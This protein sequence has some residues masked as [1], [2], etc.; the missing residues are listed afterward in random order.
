MKS[1]KL[2]EIK[3]GNNLEGAGE[4][5]VKGGIYDAESG[6]LELS[7]GQTASFECYFNIFP[8][9]QYKKYCDI[10]VFFLQIDAQGRYRT[11]I[12][13]RQ[14]NGTKLIKS[15][16]CEGAMRTDISADDGALYTFFTV[17][18]ESDC[19]FFRAAWLCAEDARR[20]TKLGMV[21]CTYR[22]EEF[23][24][25]NI[26]RI[27]AAVENKPDWKEKLHIFIVD[28]A[29][30]LSLEDSDLYTVIP[31]RN[32]GGSGGFTRGI[33][34]VCAD[35]SFS[36]FLLTD[37]DIYFDFETLE[38]T[39]A[40]IS[41][42]TCKH[43]NATV[44]G[45][46][47]YLDRPYMQHEFGGKFDG[48]IFT[49]INSKLDMRLA[50]NLL[51]NENAPAAGY[52]AWWY[53]CMP[54]S[55]V[56]NFGLPM[57]FFIKGDDVEYGMRA[58]EELIRMNGIA[59]WHQDF[60]KKFSASLEYYKRNEAVVAALATECSPFKV[61]V[62]FAYFALKNLTM[63][64]YDCTELVLKGYEDF[65]RGP[66]FFAS[67]DPFE[68]NDEIRAVQPEWISREQIEDMCGPIDIKDSQNVKLSRGERMM[69]A[70]MAVENYAPAFMF[71]KKPAVT[72][73]F[74]PKA[75][76]AFLKKTVI[77]FDE[78]SDRGF[79][80]RLD[81]ARRKKLRRRTV[82]MFFRLLTGFKK[83]RKLYREERG[84]MCSEE[85]W[86]RIFFPPQ[87]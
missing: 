63:K 25:S 70:L 28:N 48:L 57:P 84:M 79:V 65:F 17:T 67:A 18:A 73:A 35:P 8:H 4:M 34:Q 6:R 68:I 38:R 43:E 83:M 32:T 13:A 54:V 1:V 2:F 81:T 50:D 40:L 10:G 76:E 46:M 33:M 64:N 26:M 23:V 39:Y 52:N 31:N 71:S 59:V 37:D 11:D 66:Q 16:D 30:T 62:R 49:A 61:A 45:A 36:H 9:R 14:E 80:C 21:I 29:G 5:F 41:T 42:L 12:Y 78:S 47:L 75:S 19:T 20:H 56:K 87:N 51:K 60:S 85:N 86:N 82:K 77:H 74:R 72:S 58:I 44:G 15:V 24:R 22:R 69:R 3:F 53:C 7:R 27:C 55:S